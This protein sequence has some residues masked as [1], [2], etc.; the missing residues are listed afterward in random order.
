MFYL[1]IMETN[2]ICCFKIFHM[3]RR[4]LRWGWSVF[5][6]GATRESVGSH[7]DT[8]KWSRSK[9][10]ETANQLHHMYEICV[11]TCYLNCVY[12]WY[13]MVYVRSSKIQ[14]RS[15]TMMIL[16]CII[17]VFESFTSF[18][19]FV[20]H[21][22]SSPTSPRWIS[23][24]YRSRTWQNVALRTREKHQSPLRPALLRWHP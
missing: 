18:K 1:Y 2:A 7:V 23:L 16:P 13:D 20:Y 6:Q 14:M 10:N 9:W 24:Y 15:S 22:V 4:E 5:N 21:H 19:L 12:I 3:K 11:Y 17:F 8:I